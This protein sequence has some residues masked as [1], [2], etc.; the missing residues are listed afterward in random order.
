MQ[1]SV[2]V[3][4]LCADSG[5]YATKREGEKKE[6]VRGGEGVS[7]GVSG[8]GGSLRLVGSATE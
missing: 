1:C 5:Q 3:Q 7:S 6:E 4:S 2:C 8:A